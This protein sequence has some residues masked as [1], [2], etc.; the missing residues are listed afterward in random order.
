MSQLAGLRLKEIAVRWDHKAGILD[1]SGNYARDSLRMLG[2]VKKVREQVA[3]G[4]YSEAIS[5]AR[6]M[7]LIEQ[8]QLHISGPPEF[9]R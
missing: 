7:I 8:K 4:V 5:A 6:T 2:E 9:Q 3:A 1:A